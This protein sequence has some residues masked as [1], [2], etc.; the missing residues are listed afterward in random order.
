MGKRNDEIYARFLTS[1]LDRNHYGDFV[2][3]CRHLK[4]PYGVLNEIVRNETDVTGEDY[5]LYL[6]TK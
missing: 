6:S 4:V 1:V 5:M 2:S 3:V